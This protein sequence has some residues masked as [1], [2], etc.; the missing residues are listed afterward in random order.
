MRHKRAERSGEMQDVAGQLDSKTD[1]DEELVKRTK[2]SSGIGCALFD[3]PF[4][5]PSARSGAV[6]YSLVSRKGFRDIGRSCLEG[7]S[8][9]GLLCGEGEVVR[10]R[11]GLLEERLS[12]KP[13][14]DRWRSVMTRTG[15]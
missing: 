12:V 9:K 4:S 5:T 6:L 11:K 13:T 2:M 1:E 15:Q 7:D 10:L 14:G 8:L 3:L